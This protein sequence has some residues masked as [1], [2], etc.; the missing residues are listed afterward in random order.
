MMETFLNPF[1]FTD[2]KKQK[3]AAG[4][5]SLKTI[6]TTRNS[7]FVQSSSI[8]YTLNNHQK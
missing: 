6:N 7:F 2:K 3:G 4:T 5:C 8:R 1:D